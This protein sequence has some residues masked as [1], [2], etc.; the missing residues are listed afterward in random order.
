M[1]STTPDEGV[2]QRLSAGDVNGDGYAD[3][4]V[5]VRGEEID[6]KNNAG[7]VHVFKGRASGLS[8]TGSQWFA[9]NTPGVPGALTADDQ[10]GGLVRLRDTNG[11]GRAD[12]H[13]SAT[14]DLRLPGSAGGITTTGAT[15]YDAVPI[16]SFLQ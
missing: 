16:T 14:G 1:T 2:H 11:D 5:G 4:A 13:V 3:L 6:G 12:L 7:G 8:G 15:E 10:F 9:R